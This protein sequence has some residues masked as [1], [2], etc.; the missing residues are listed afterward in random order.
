MPDLKTILFPPEVIE[1]IKFICEA[2]HLGFSVINSDVFAIIII[3]RNE[4]PPNF[5]H[6]AAAQTI[7]SGIL[8]GD[9]SEANNE[10]TIQKES[11]ERKPM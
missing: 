6:L 11:R 5:I 4:L 9:W 3:G 10:A 2:E 1:R 8:S 7:I